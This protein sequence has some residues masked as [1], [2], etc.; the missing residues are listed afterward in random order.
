METR[1]CC[2]PV[3]DKYVLQMMR[4]HDATLGGEQSGHILFPAY[5]TTGD[6]LM[7]ALLVLDMVQRSGT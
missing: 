6:G 4:E 1:S 3:G 5:S 2:W 7:T